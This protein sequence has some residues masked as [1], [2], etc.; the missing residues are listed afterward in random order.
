MRDAL[1]PRLRLVTA[2]AEPAHG[3]LCR[4]AARNACECPRAFARDVG[5]DPDRLRYGHGVAELEMAARLAAGALS[6]W[7]P[8]VE[9]MA[10]R[11]VIGIE[12]L[13]TRDWT[14]ASRRWCPACVRDDRSNTSGPARRWATFHRAWWD[15]T[16]IRCCP[17]HGTEL[18]DRCGRCGSAQGWDRV[19]LHACDCGADLGRVPAAAEADRFGKYVHARLVGSSVH[20]VPFLDGLTLAAVVPMVDRLGQVPLVGAGT[21]WARVDGTPAEGARER[22]FEIA[23]GWPTAFE[24][25]LDSTLAVSRQTG[26]PPGMLGA[27]GWI[28]EAWVSCL[29]AEDGGAVLRECLRRHAVRNGVVAEG[30]AGTEV[31][32]R[33][34]LK[35]A[36]AR[37]GTGHDR[38][39][40]ILAARG[41]L[42]RGRRRSV[43]VP[44]D[45]AEVARIATVMSTLID[46]ST[47]ARRLGVGRGV[48]RSIAN[49]GRIGRS[50]EGAAFGLSGFDAGALRTF[51]DR[52]KGN[53]RIVSR[54]PTG[55]KPL[56]QACQASGV[57]VA[58]AL[59]LVADGKLVPVAVLAGAPP[60]AG[61]LVRVADLGPRRRT[62]GADV[63][64]VEAA[65]MAGVHPDA[66]LQLI[67][68]SA[69][70]ARRQAGRWS[71]RCIDMERF[72]E[73]HISGAQLART[74]RTSPRNVVRVL[75]AAGCTP[76]FGPPRFRQVVFTQSA[77][78][79]AAFV[80][81]KGGPGSRSP[82]RHL[83]FSKGLSFDDM[84]ALYAASTKQRTVRLGG[85][86]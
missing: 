29:P 45:A 65:S 82:T 64:I 79:M 86:S 13:R 67:R 51:A 44:V 41:A 62:A 14:V 19:E 20:G 7:S 69:I 70:P 80:L 66:M 26:R 18:V 71:I 72:V 4:L 81:N 40:R 49:E 60:V 38:T 61:L 85:D 46:L 2:G 63:T 10:R 27:Y 52:L 8:K 73:E 35:T 84:G 9:A 42:P 30:E 23:S 1:R 25:C 33:I 78:S 22:G 15:V 28:H 76:A 6:R 57:S 5:I 39:K 21:R 75:N 48:M 32:S 77:V 56:P 16:A 53:A 55:T 43:A 11:V 54:A 50:D 58:K 31:G 59:G 12:T 83:H 24:D 17:D 74:L 3:Y 34:D 47:A 36:A 37:L 68:A